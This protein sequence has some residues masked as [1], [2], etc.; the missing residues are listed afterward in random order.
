MNTIHS[1]SA[2]CTTLALLSCMEQRTYKI[3]VSQCSRDDWR[4][5]MNA[6]IEREAMFHEDARVE[7]RS[8]D[9]SNEKQAD[10]IRYFVENGFD[11]ICVAPN[12]AEPL[13]PIVDEAFRAGVPIIIF[14]RNILSHSYTARISSDDDGLGRSAARYALGLLGVEARAVE[15]RGRMGS[16]P[17][18]DRH[19]GFADEF[20]KGGGCL[21]GGAT[22]LW[23]KEDAVRVADSLLCRHPEANI[24]FAH[25]DRMAQGA[26]EVLRRRKM[27]GQ[28]KVIGIDAAPDIGVRA[29]ADGEI[30]ATFI[31]PTEGHRLVR[32]AMAIL[33]GQD[34]D[35]DVTLPLSSAVDKTNAD[36]LLAQDKALKEETDRMKTL[37]ERIDDYWARHS[38]QTALFY[39]TLTIALLLAC[40]AALLLRAYWQRIHHQRE[41][42]AQN[43]LLKEECDN[44]RRLNEQLDEA[45]QSK[46]SFFTNVSH[47]LRTPLT[48]IAEPV[49]QLAKSPNLTRVQKTLVSIADKNVRILRRLVDQVL[50][51]R[52]LD[53]GKTVLRL[54]E[55]DVAQVVRYWA[56][57]FSTTARKRDIDVRVAIEGGTR[58]EMAIDVEKMESVFFNLVSNALKHTPDNG[59]LDL[60]LASDGQ[61]LTLTVADN[62][63]GIA[64]DELARVF[65]RF[66]QGQGAHPGG[67]GLG[68]ALSKAFVEL[69]GGTIAVRSKRGEGTTFTVVI[70]VRHVDNLLPEACRGLDHAA[71]EAELSAAER[72]DE[73]TPADKRRDLVLVIDDNR[74]MLDLLRETLAADYSV[75]VATDGRQGVKM[76]VKYV[77]DLVVCD[78]M[79]PGMDGLECCRRIK[80]NVASSHVP[81]V[82]LTACSTDEQRAQGYD[83]GADGYLAKPFSGEVLRARVRNLIAG[84]R[85]IRDLWGGGAVKDAAAPR[86]DDGRKRDLPMSDIDNEFYNHFLRVFKERM[87]D[88]SLS[89]DSLAGEMGLE[90]SQFYRKLKA[91]T[92]YSPVELIR[93]LRL[94]HAKMLLVQ[95]EMTVSQIAYETGFS[96]PAYFTKCFREAFG[97]TPT[98][99]RVKLAG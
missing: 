15:I 8:A 33:K 53:S 95:S 94:N 99:T 75:I 92:N 83:S 29:V 76:A 14:D 39:T 70:P 52:R 91:V 19:D 61:T 44:Q 10:D 57:A 87:G 16:T 77:P 27:E 37:K 80:G 85:V 6:E 73:A 13:T 7:I 84:R 51:F 81:V 93:R 20:A 43:V 42:T 90:R 22:G 12:E 66:Y 38:S 1:V 35:R 98:E 21:L 4:A 68:L 65:D 86:P 17:A 34:Y 55:A 49:A 67:S 18:V 72:D 41:L 89:V 9:D 58:F 82:M 78:I 64:D 97:E 30:D 48:L 28:V 5:K 46:L 2:I 45:T 59:R 96:S 74:D 50:D 47:D 26:A 3:G 24:V 60:G 62:G 54:A 40:I 56:E 63:D 31:Y 71:V 79:M 32:T 25:N 11:L 69:H 88:A 36:I 23:N